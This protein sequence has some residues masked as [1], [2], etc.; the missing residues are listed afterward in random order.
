MASALSP[1]Y[2]TRR[3]SRRAKIFL[4]VVVFLIALRA[5]LPW[6][7]KTYINHVLQN[8]LMGYTG[9]V[10]DVDLSLWRGAYQLERLQLLKVE[11]KIPV[12]FL[13]FGHT[14]LRIAWRPLFKGRVVGEIE[15]TDARVNLV[16]GPGQGETQTGAE[17]EGWQAAFDK[18]FPLKVNRLAVHRSQIH[19]MDFHSKPKVDV[20]LHELEL[21]ATNLSNVDKGKK[22]LPSSIQAKALVQ[23]DGKLEANATADILR[24]PPAMDLNLSLTQLDLPGL[25]DFL[26]AYGNF[27]L[28][29]G[30][31]DLYAEAVTKEGQIKGY[32][33]PF[34][35]DVDVLQNFKEDFSS[36]GQAFSE[37][38]VSTV[39]LVVR[40]YS[41]DQVAT[42]I[43]FEGR[44]DNPEVKTWT[45]V[46]NLIRH[47]FGTPQKPR[48][49]AEISARS[50]P[51]RRDRKSSNN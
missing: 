51:G 46:G 17:G 5:A 19:Y 16:S 32:V 12:P 1:E 4:G 49:D 45:A 47:A 8:D 6:I 28:A 35:T 2:P 37:L 7:L 26:K 15:M 38:V 41:K 36:Q 14:D 9:S 13:D 48:I 40:R 11:G 34:L 18:I 22:E 43:P 29:K 27:N 3:L 44:I 31:L 23:K 33:K 42:K 30:R 20:S 21:N 10:A 24:E 50:L 25:N 39:N